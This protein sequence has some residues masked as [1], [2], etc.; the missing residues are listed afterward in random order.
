MAEFGLDVQE[1]DELLADFKS[2]DR[3]GSGEISLE[4]AE[5][6][7]AQNQEDI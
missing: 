4:R 1:F 5:V 6:A 7:I 2:I 3:D